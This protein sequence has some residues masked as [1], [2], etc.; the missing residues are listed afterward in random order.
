MGQGESRTVSS[1]AAPR[2]QLLCCP[3]SAEAKAEATMQGC[4]SV[5]SPVLSITHSGKE[6]REES[7]F[8]DCFSCSCS[9]FFPFQI[10]EIKG[11]NTS[12]RDLRPF[13]GNICMSLA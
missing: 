8:R 7:L 13:H 1:L 3:R 5:P 6:R 11:M 9:S 4:S 2:S 10:Y 12:S